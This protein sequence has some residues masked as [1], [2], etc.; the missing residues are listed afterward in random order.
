MIPHK[1]LFQ[2]LLKSLPLLGIVCCS[3]CHGQFD[4]FSE[5]YRFNPNNKS[6]YRLTPDGMTWENAQMY[7]RSH[8]IGGLRIP[9][10]LATIRSQEENQWLIS[11]NSGLLSPNS[12]R[13]IGFTD[14]DPPST[15][16]T[17]I[18]ISG[19]FGFFNASDRVCGG[20]CNFPQDVPSPISDADYAVLE[21]A[22]G[23]SPGAWFVDVNQGSTPSLPWFGIIEF[24][25]P[26][27]GAHDD[28]NENGIPDTWEDNNQNGLPDGFEDGGPFPAARNLRA[29][30]GARSVRLVW[31]PAD[32]EDLLGYHVYRAESPAFTDSTRVNTGGLLVDTAFLDGV[33]NGKPLDPGAVYYYRVDSILDIKGILEVG[34]SEIVMAT[35][36]EFVFSLPQ[37]RVDPSNRKNLRYPISLLNA[38]GVDESGFMLQVEYPSFL[39]EVSVENTPLTRHYPTLQIQNNPL[40]NTIQFRWNSTTQN[41]PPLNGEGAIVNLVFSIGDTVPIGSRG[42]IRI[43]GGSVGTVPGVA[44]PVDFSDIGTITLAPGFQPGDINGNGTVNFADLIASASLAFGVVPPDPR[45]VAAGDVNNDGVSDVADTN[46]IAVLIGLKKNGKSGREPTHPKGTDDFEIKMKDAAFPTLPGEVDME[47]EI[48]MPPAESEGIAGAAFTVSYATEYVELMG[49]ELDSPDF[50]ALFYDQRD[51]SRG[52][53]PGRVKVIVSSQENSVIN[54]KVAKVRFGTKGIPQVPTSEVPFVSGKMAKS[55]GEDIE[56]NSVVNLEEGTLIFESAP[57]LDINV[58]VDNIIN[59]SDLLIFIDRIKTGT[60]ESEILNEF[61]KEWLTPR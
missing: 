7:A 10:N 46:I 8:E 12:R 24:V 16:G 49:V 1:N 59:A 21:D 29:G 2:N 57:E 25:E 41:L 52:W 53:K 9:G 44:S 18:W 6:V 22:R 30:G 50:G 26:F 4:F 19:E 51:Y 34:R 38:R 40:V 13:W 55:S 28:N 27:V 20:F 14:A 33:D 5:G 35:V 17:W 61:S 31:D 60:Q 39:S 47:V 11:P 3:V 54:G 36:G 42:A 43:L 56:W 32:S 58:Y 15:E 48:A 45:F 23:N 37:I